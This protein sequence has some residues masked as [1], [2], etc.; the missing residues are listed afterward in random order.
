MVMFP[1]PQMTV[2]KCLYCATCKEVFSAS[3]VHKVNGHAL[4]KVHIC[5]GCGLAGKYDKMHPCHNHSQKAD[6]NFYEI[7]AYF[8]A[9]VGAAANST[10]RK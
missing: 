7:K 2:Y 10:N 6:L 5:L 9:V 8:T 3:S 4:V 1:L